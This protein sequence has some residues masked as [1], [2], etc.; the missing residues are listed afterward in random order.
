METRHSVD[1]FIYNYDLNQFQEIIENHI[2]NYDYFIILPHFKNE[3][4][5]VA[6]VIKKIPQE[7]VL[8]V[9]RYLESLKKYPIV[10]QEYEKDI[11]TALAKGI[12]L[13]GNTQKLILFFL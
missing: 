11:Q 3:N 10:Y 12:D 9:D 5:D 7:K 8:I 1:V 4:D 2:S 13:F 6:G